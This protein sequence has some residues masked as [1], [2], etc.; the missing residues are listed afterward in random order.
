MSGT[1]PHYPWS[2]GDALFASELNAAI[3]NS[4]AYGPFLSTSG[5]A[6]RGSLTVNGAIR[7]GANMPIDFSGDGTDVGQNVRTLRYNSGATALEYKTGATTRLTLS[8]TKPAV[9]GSRAGN[10]ALASLLIA[11]AA[12]NLVTDSSTA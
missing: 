10:A 1:R 5:G 12:A 2:E 6:L 4:A 9:T 8:D 7:L 3:A 11:L